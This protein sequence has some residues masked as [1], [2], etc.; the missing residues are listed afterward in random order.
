MLPVDP[1]ADARARVRRGAARGARRV[2]RRPGRDGHLGDLVADPA[3]RRR[4]GHR[5]R[6]VRAGVPDGPAAAVARDHPDL[7]VLHGDCAS[8]LEFGSLPW[9]DAAI[10]GLDPRPRPE[11]D[12][13][14][15]GQ[16]GRRRPTLLD[17][18]GSDAVR[19]WAANGR[20]RGGHRVRPRRSSR[21][22]GGW[23]SR[24][25][26]RRSSCCRSRRP[27][28][29]VDRRR[30]DQSLLAALDGVVRRGDRGAR[31]RT[32][33]PARSR[34]SSGSSGCSATTTSSW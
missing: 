4:L 15:Q 31:R 8:H 20:L 30:V 33:T 22:A 34:R 25:S 2:H 29:P 11:E 19:Y 5:P 27:A 23:R 6:P 13:E 24:S 14:V 18:Y 17:Q 9:S 10:S 12:V 1:V 7:A 26:T 32:T 21:S 28:G 16:R 3:D